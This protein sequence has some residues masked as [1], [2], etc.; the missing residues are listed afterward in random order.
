[1]KVTNVPA[2]TVVA[3]DEME[4]DAV[5]L[6]LTVKVMPVEVAVVFVKQVGKVPPAVNTAETVWPLV[7][8]KVKVVPVPWAVPFTFHV[9]VGAVPPLVPA[10]VKVTLAPV[11]TEAEVVAIETD[12]VWVGFTVNVVPV[13]VAVALVKQ[14]GKVPP[15]VRTDVTVWPFVGAR[16]N[17]LPAPWFAPFTYQVYVGVEPGLV[18]VAVKVTLVP[19]QT[20]AAE[21]A[22]ETE[23]VW[24]G[25]TVNVVPVEVA[26][27]FVRQADT[28]P[29]AVNTALTVWPF[30]GTKLKV[31]PV[32]WVAPLTFQV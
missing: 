4:T 11:H 8:V 19:A 24:V 27:V 30:V 9:Y 18:P 15:A 26:V 28:V 6:E 2:Q 10:A 25:L 1:V 12:A 14:V 7:G 3:D 22:I 32:P 17:V 31:V 16:L 20:V 13:E 23:A 21:D 5:R 29:P